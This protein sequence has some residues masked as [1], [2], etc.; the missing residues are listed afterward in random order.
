MAASYLFVHYT[1]P[2]TQSANVVPDVAST[3]AATAVGGAGLVPWLK[4]VALRAAGAEGIAE[5]VGVPESSGAAPKASVGPMT[6][7]MDTSG[8]GFAIWLNVSYLLPLTYLFVRFFVRSYLYRKDPGPRNPAHMNAAEKAGLDA[9]KGVSRAIQKSVEMNGESS[10]TTED[11]ATKARVPP[12]SAK[13]PQEPVVAHDSPIRTRASAKQKARAA[14]NETEQGFSPVSSKKGA[15]MVTQDEL[16]SSAAIDPKD[17]NP[18]E[19]LDN[20]A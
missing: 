10:E 6:T 20:K 17:G 15:K 8:Q 1:L 5:N 13:T 9:L 11:E 2:P 4:Q 16:E 7:C 19:V 18:F 3:V 14:A 12:P